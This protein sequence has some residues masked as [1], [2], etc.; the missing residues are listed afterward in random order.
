MY[1]G[2]Q[3]FCPEL[4]VN[5][6][7]V[8]H[9]ASKVD[10]STVHSF[11]HPILLRDIRDCELIMD[12]VVSQVR[13]K[14]IGDVFATIICAKGFDSATT[15]L[16]GILAKLSDI[17]SAPAFVRMGYTVVHLE[18]SSMNLMKQN[19]PPSDLTDIGPTKTE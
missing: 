18:L 6:L 11:N 8:Q 9:A 19:D 13:L 17:F 15:V 16:L 3:G 7:V 14:M 1:G 5:T 2:G 4:E 12:A 10:E